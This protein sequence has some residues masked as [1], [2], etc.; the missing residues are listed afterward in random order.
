MIKAEREDGTILY[1]VTKHDFI[2]IFVAHI[3][4]GS[5]KLLAGGN[6][7]AGVTFKPGL[8]DDYIE[9]EV[10]PVSPEEAS[11]VPK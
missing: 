7:R 2:N 8:E 5:G 6:Y 11:E 10:V 1:T 4:R 3:E 9:V